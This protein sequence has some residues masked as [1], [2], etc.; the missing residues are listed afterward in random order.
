MIMRSTKLAVESWAE[1]FCSTQV[2]ANLHQITSCLEG[3]S[4]LGTFDCQAANPSLKTS[5][6]GKFGEPWKT[7]KNNKRLCWVKYALKDHPTETSNSAEQHS[8]HSVFLSLSE[9][10]EYT[11]RSSPKQAISQKYFERASCISIHPSRKIDLC[12]EGLN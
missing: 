5:N 7:T 9:F 6:W 8:P 4:K 3:T 10:L 12:F 1:K 11:S 2:F